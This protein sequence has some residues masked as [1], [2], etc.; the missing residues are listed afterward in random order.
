MATHLFS[1]Q[2]MPL[3][4]SSKVTANATVTALL[5]DFASHFQPDSIIRRLWQTINVQML[6]FSSLIILFLLN[7]SVTVSMA[8]KI[9]QKI[10]EAKTTCLKKPQLD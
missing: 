5:R 6:V 4:V 1:S 8:L 10:D 3:T 7:D 2:Y 9:Q